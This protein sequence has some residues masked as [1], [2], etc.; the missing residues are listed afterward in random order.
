MKLN[1]R[2]WLE[3]LRTSLWVVPM[4]LV[5]GMMLLAQLLLWLDAS[6]GFD[7]AMMAG[8]GIEG[9]RG[10]F[11][12]VAGSMI[13]LAGLVFSMT[14]VVLSQASAQYSSRVLRN[15]LGDRINQTVLGV[16][17]GIFAYCL[18]VL[19]G[20]GDDESTL[21]GLTVLVGVAMALLGVV[22]LIYFIHHMARSMQVENIVASIQEETLPVIDRLYPENEAED[23]GGADRPVPEFGPG[24]PVIMARSSGYIQDV[25]LEC[26]ADLACRLDTV[27][28]LPLRVGDFV[29]EGMALVRI[30]APVEPD[31]AAAS[32]VH[33]SFTL[34]R[35]RTIQQDP[36]FG[37]RQLVD[38]AMKAL[39]PGVNDTTSA[40]LV[41]DRISV[42]VRR[43]CQR[44]MPS[45]LREVDGRLRLVVARPDFEDLLGLAFDQIRQWGANNP[46][47][48]GRMLEVIAELLP[49]T[50][51]SARRALLHEHARRIMAAAGHAIKE[52]CDLAWLRQ[53][54]ERLPPA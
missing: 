51:G 12:A 19:R 13:T 6:A 10:M 23:A 53:C 4:G 11:Q 1:P 39:S 45:R 54:H 16:F 26:L 7:F 36:S 35:Q 29:A 44:R 48:L 20:M 27:I 38:V 46:A 2:V 31:S 3:R 8:A 43:L 47:V 9:A 42:L 15:F 33:R 25:D 40:V 17:L 49:V 14:L 34:G 28:E 22:F 24:S 50:R 37:L 18:I 30:M 32:A 52:E 21:P 41:V 5:F